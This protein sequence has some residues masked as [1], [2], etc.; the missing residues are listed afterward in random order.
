MISEKRTVIRYARD[1]APGH[2]P[3]VRHEGEI[4]VSVKEDQSLRSELLLENTTVPMKQSYILPENDTIEHMA[5]L[6]TKQYPPLSTHDL[7]PRPHLLQKLHGGTKRKLSLISAPA[8]FGK[9]TL[10]KEWV[11]STALPVA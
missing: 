7:V 1:I 10:L 3:I 9:T 2:Q 5:L 11:Q 8:G 4:N 6:V